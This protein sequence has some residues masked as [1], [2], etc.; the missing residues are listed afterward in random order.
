MLT[1]STKTNIYKYFSFLLDDFGFSITEE[2]YDQEMGNAVVGFSKN[3]TCIELIKDRGQIL[4]TLGDKRLSKWDWVEF[5]DAIGFLS[6]NISPV[7]IFQS[8]NKNVTEESQLSR[9]SVLMKQHCL[10]ILS[11]EMS[12]IQL[13]DA[14]RSKRT[15]ETRDFLDG[16][17]KE[18]M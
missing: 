3:Q 9:V 17:N 18:S 1:D 14:I 15:Q 10:V 13:R 11:G 16:H 4:V 7:Y 6:G 12:V 2:R 5:A 8:Q